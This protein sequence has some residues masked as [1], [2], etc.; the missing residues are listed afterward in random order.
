MSM[1]SREPADKGVTLTEEQLAGI[2]AAAQCSPGSAGGQP[3]PPRAGGAHAGTSVSYAVE[4]TPGPW[5]GHDADGYAEV[6]G[7]AVGRGLVDGLGVNGRA[8][9]MKRSPPGFAEGD[10]GLDNTWFNPSPD[11][12]PSFHSNPAHQ[13]LNSG[14]TQGTRPGLAFHQSSQEQVAHSGT[15]TQSRRDLMYQ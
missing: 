4:E 6:G 3:N 15:N 10:L 14:D 2:W 9:M 5:M 1:M 7:E 12:G 11:A 8:A 13:L